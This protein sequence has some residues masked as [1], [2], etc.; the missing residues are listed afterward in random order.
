[1][2]SKDQAIGWLIFIVC[3]VIMIGYVVTLFGY[4]QIVKPLLN[5]PWSTRGVQFWLVAIPVLI[6]FIAILAIGAW[7]G[8]TMATTPPPR[9]IEE[10]E[11]EEKTEEEEKK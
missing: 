3:V 5:L 2:V 9:P 1:M 7:I 8:W 6:A 11:L 4:E 10:I